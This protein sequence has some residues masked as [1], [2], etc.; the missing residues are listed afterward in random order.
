LLCLS[1]TYSDLLD[2]VIFAVLL[3]FAL[4]I[5]ALFLLRAKRPDIPRPYK[6]WGYPVVPAL[7]ILTTT[8]I[9]V[10]LLIFKPS[11]TFP[12]LVIVLLGIPVYYLWRKFT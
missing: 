4:T 1:G 5:F 3:F 9:M 7:Y 12:G 6:A 10:I 2:Y 11:Y 8:F